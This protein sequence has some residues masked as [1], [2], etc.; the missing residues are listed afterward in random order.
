MISYLGGADIAGSALKE[1]GTVHWGSPNNDATNT[2]GFT[3]L[4]AGMIE[5]GLVSGDITNKAYFWSATEVDVTYAA[6]KGLAKNSA[7]VTTDSLSRDDMISVR[8]KKD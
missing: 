4:P 2:S 8:C 6:G 7:A 1:T 5:G 3:A